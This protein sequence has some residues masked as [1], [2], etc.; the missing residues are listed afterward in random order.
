[1]AFSID[2]RPANKSEK[3]MTQPR[4]MIVQSESMKTFEDMVKD[5]AHGAKHQE[6]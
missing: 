1:M 4:Y 5:H 3:A 2:G 6:E